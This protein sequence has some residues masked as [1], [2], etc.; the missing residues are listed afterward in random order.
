MVGNGI[1]S[2]VKKDRVTVLVRL[3][4][5]AAFDTV[6]YSL[7]LYR[8]LQ[9]RFGLSGPALNWFARDLCSRAQL[10]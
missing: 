10:E 4:S 3:E 7:L 5:F 2:S 9:Q 6:N 1:M 8:L